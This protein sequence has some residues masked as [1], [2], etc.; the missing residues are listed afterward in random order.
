MIRVASA[1]PHTA[2]ERSDVTD[3]RYA[4]LV[5]IRIIRPLNDVKLSADNSAGIG[6]CIGIHVNLA[7]RPKG[8]R[9]LS[10]TSF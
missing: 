8:Q 3:S 2:A 5:V 10:A 1:D 9:G 6:D 7:I 4:A